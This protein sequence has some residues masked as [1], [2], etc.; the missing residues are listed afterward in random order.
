MGIQGRW[1]VTPDNLEP[2]NKKLKQTETLL[3]VIQLKVGKF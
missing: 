2:P 1:Q 3:D